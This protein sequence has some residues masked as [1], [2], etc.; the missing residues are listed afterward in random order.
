M[1]LLILILLG[2]IFALFVSIQ[3]LKGRLT[4]IEQHLGA[5]DGGAAR[6]APETNWTP[7]PVTNVP[8]AEPE[9]RPEPEPLPAATYAVGYTKMPEVAEDIEAPVDDA[10]PVDEEE[11]EKRSA[12]CSSDSSPA[13]C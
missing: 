2:G 5:M 4:R 9:L 11:E 13:S 10:S 1:E 3:N 6:S 12:G 8:S 7:A